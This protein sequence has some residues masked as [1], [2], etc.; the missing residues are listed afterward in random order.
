VEADPV[1][2][3]HQENN[4]LVF[5]AHQQIKVLGIPFQKLGKDTTADVDTITLL[6]PVDRTTE[7]PARFAGANYATTTKTSDLSGDERFIVLGFKALLW[8]KKIS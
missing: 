7:F 8:K 2:V 6:F 3:L 1:T 5:R 4:P